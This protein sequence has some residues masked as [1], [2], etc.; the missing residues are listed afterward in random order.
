MTTAITPKRPGGLATPQAAADSFSQGLRDAK[1]ANTRRAYAVQWAGFEQ[2]TA[3]NGLAALPATPPTVAAYLGALHAAGR[4]IAT[5]QLARAAI[6]F[7]HVGA[8]IPQADNPAKHPTIAEALKGWRRTAADP[9]QAA[10][11]TGAALEAIR[12]SAMLPR[13]GRGGALE[14][15]DAAK[16][17]GRADIA[18]CQLVSDAGLRRTEAAALTWADV[19][20]WAEVEAWADGGRV[21]I[22]RGKNHPNESRTVAITPSTV[23]ALEAVRP[24]G[25]APADSVFGLSDTQLHRRIRAA[26][27]A[28]G[29]GP[30]FGG[31]S[32]R[33]GLARRMTAAGAPSQAVQLQ[34]RWKNPA[35]ISHYTRGE[36][37]GAA[38]KYLS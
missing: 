28:A 13:A 33:V 5:I 1:A 9:R 10:A 11:L 27:E 30:D 12:T 29:L 20:A 4:A 15:P 34:G 36:A 21:R 38:L 3:D 32:G 26:A 2:W 8:G 25:A 7:H 14:T 16:V 31:H 22:A 24:D 6:S 35:M 23:R 17:R 37:A 18:L 19:E